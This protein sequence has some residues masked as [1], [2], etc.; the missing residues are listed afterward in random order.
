MAPEDDFEQLL[1]RVRAGDE[2]AASSLYRRT[3][4]RLVRYLRSQEPRHADDLAAEVW[5]AVAGQLDEFDGDEAGFRAWVFTM[6]RRRVLDHRRRGLRRRTDAVAPADLTATELD[7]GLDPV[8]LAEAQDA[9]DLITAVLPPAQAEVVILRVL[10][11]LDAETVA[12]IVGRSANWV[13]VNQHR[14]LRRLAMKVR[15][16][17]DVA[18]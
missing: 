6:A 4:P 3:H 1:A 12:R 5:L 13:R 17:T 10:S 11:D 7:A 18:T 8:E 14:G 9:V 2:A 16:T 15:R